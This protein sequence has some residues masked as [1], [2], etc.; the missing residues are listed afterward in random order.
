LEEF[1]KRVTFPG[2]SIKMYLYELKGLLRQAMLELAEDASQQLLIHHFLA[3]LPAQ[4]SSQ[5]Q[6]VGNTTNLEQIV[7]RA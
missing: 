4:V 2:E 1:Q 7:E 3:G 6:A 5:L